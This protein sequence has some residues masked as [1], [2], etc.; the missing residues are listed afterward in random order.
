MIVVKNLHFIQIC[1]VT[2][3]RDKSNLQIKLII[4]IALKKIQYISNKEKLNV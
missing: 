4:P 2:Q 1:D 3:I